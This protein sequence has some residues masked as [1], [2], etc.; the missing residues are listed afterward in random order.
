MRLNQQQVPD[1]AT[2]NLLIH[3]LGAAGQLEKCLDVFLDMQHA[4][5]N[6]SLTSLPLPA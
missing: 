2:Y 5:D 6:P 3:G 4:G 1:E